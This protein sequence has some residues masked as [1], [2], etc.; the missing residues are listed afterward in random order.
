[1][2]LDKSVPKHEL[3]L[4]IREN[5]F[6]PKHP[7]MA[8][9]LVNLAKKHSEALPLHE[10]AL[11][12]YVKGVFEK[13]AELFKQ[14]MEIKEALWPLVDTRPVGTCLVCEGPSLSHMPPGDPSLYLPSE[15][16]R[17]WIS[18]S[19]S[20]ILCVHFLVSF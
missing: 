8:T 6:G 4:D 17:W 1:G 2:K 5:S 20:L 7:S 19:L 14:S 16:H 15:E 11:R 10:K 12:V 18:F 13:A 9:A 3:A